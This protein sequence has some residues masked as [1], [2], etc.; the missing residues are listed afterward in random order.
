MKNK[1]RELVI[2][3]FAGHVD[4]SNQPYVEHLFRV[5]DQVKVYANDSYPLEVFETVALLHDLLEDCPEWTPDRL[6]GYFPEEGIVEAVEV[7]TKAPGQVYEDYIQRIKEHPIA[8]AV[9][10]ADLKDNMDVTRLHKLTEKAITRLKKY[11]R[12]YKELV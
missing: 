7:L 1:A 9:K 6:R 2:H 3:A 10:L 11:H 5:M 12:A 8:R 4:K